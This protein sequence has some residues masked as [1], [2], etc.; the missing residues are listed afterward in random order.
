MPDGNILKLD[1]ERYECSEI[2][3]DS[4]SFNKD[5]IKGINELLYS[6]IMKCDMDVRKD[7]KYNIIIFGGTS[8]LPG[9][10]ERLRKEMITLFDRCKIV[11]PPERLYSVWI[12]GSI[13]ASLSTFQT[14]W[15]TADDYDE[16]GMDI[17]HRKSF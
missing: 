15:I 11:A 3:F 13:L 8:N 1:V 14:R 10:Q 6:S 5:C 7:L 2:L 17:V 12:G 16:Y 9:M 4:S